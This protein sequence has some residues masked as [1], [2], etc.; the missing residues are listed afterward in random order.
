MNRLKVGIIGCGA[1]GRGHIRGYAEI[2]EAEVIAVA[3]LNPERA[4]GVAAEFGIRHNYTDYREMLT[5]H[6][7]DIVSLAL[8]PAANRDAAMAAF[9]A[10]AHVLISK[11]LAMN[12][13]EAEEMIATARRCGKLMS[14]GLQNRFDPDV[15]ALRRFLAAG[16]L[17][18][19]YH[20]RIWHGHVMH[21]PGTPTMYKRCLAGGGVLFHTTV[22]LLDAIL[23][24]LGNPKPVHVSGGSYRKVSQMKTPLVTWSG[25]VADCDIEDFNIGL[26]HFADGSTMT[27]ESNWMM[28]PRARPSGAEILGDWGVASL[29]PLRVELEDGERIVDATPH[30]DAPSQCS[31]VYQ[32]FCQ[33]VLENRLP[34]VRFG[35]MLD[36]QR[37]M[38]AL[39]EAAE[40]GREV[41]IAD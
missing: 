6:A 2:P 24:A 7:L 29:R 20:T 18:H 5:R 11:P 40:K 17:G 36:V 41:A 3:E 12:L 34:V 37:V 23:W 10:G 15:R 14:M 22:H 26:V 33:S 19:V 27:V 39:Y 32:D 30:T 25:P 21:I 31:S 1:H 13:A 9:E 4:T 8:P 28:H 38:N 35:E 16:K